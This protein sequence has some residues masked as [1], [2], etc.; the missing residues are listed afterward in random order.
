MPT[1]RSLLFVVL[2]HLLPRLCESKAFNLSSFSPCECCLIIV[3]TIEPQ[4]V[5]EDSIQADV[6]VVMLSPKEDG[7]R[8]VDT[9]YDALKPAVSEVKVECDLSIGTWRVWNCNL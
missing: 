5:V 7:R 4:E 3:S 8:V 1:K 6:D 2:V 9:G